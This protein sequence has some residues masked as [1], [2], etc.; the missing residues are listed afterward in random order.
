MYAVGDLEIESESQ[1]GHKLFLPRRLS[2]WKNLQDE[3]VSLACCSR[4]SVIS[5]RAMPALITAL[6]GIPIRCSKSLALI[7]ISQIRTSLF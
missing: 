6:A 4:R 5:W 3:V 1:F 7:E 2:N